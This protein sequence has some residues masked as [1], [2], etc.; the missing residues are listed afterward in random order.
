M[1]VLRTNSR[2]ALVV[3]A[4]IGLFLLQNQALEAHT[5]EASSEVSINFE[6]GK[7]R[8][9]VTSPRERCVRNRTV[10]VFKER[11]NQPDLL[12]GQDQTNDQGRY[13]VDKPRGVEGK[14]YAN[15]TQRTTGDYPHLHRCREAT[16]RTI[17]VD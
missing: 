5:S 10:E 16:S 3:V 17:R 15:V 11:R 12:I 9:R 4:M 2:V 8:G 14:F 13:S 6:D 1:A 7:F